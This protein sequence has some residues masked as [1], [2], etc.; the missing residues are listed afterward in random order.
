MCFIEEQMGNRSS[1]TGLL[2]S[3]TTAQ[4]CLRYES[5]HRRYVRNVCD[6]SNKTLF[7]KRNRVGPQAGACQLL[8]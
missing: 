6:C 2:V 1:F 3:A 8:L 5:T 4:L 7:T